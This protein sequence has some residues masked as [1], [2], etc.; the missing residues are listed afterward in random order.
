[1]EYGLGLETEEVVENH[2]EDVLILVIMEYGLGR[3]RL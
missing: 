2:V 1:M 3:L